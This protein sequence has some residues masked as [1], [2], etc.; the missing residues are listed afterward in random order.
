M[1]EANNQQYSADVW[2]VPVDEGWRAAHGVG[3][4]YYDGN[5]DQVRQLKL[6]VE[7]F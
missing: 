4:F 1:M 2:Q 5:C 3:N 7:M 6:M